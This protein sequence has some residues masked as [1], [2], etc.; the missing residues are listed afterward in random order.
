[1]MRKKRNKEK[2]PTLLLNYTSLNTQ[3]NVDEHFEEIEGSMTKI[4]ETEE[5]IDK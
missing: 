5:A 3:Q 4:T 2:E 1:M